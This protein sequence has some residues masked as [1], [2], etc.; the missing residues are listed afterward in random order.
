VSAEGVH[1]GRLAEARLQ[2]RQAKAPCNCPD[3]L[4]AQR[5]AL[6]FRRLANHP[7][8]CRHRTAVLRRSPVPEFSASSA[9]LQSAAHSRTPAREL[10]LCL[11]LP[12]L[13]SKA[14]RETPRPRPTA[15]TV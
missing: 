12:F 5:S 10:N 13:L 14:R 1:G 4:G 15:Q 3:P 6:A 7:A 11:L 8:R 2:P 9:L